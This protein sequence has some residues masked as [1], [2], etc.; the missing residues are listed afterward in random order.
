MSHRPA[1]SADLATIC[2]F[3]QSAEELFFLFPKATFPL[4]PEQLQRAMDQRADATV[5]ELRGQV[6][7]Y[8]NFYQ[9]AQGGRCAIGNVII[10]PA[11]RGQGVGRYLINR[12]V[13]LAISR[14]AA[15]EVTVACFNHNVSALLLYAGMGFEPYAIE[16]RVDHQGQRVA[17]IQLRRALPVG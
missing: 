1:T 4:T 2:G 14:Y 11:A 9:W 16:E 3:P 10:A 17:L 6:V 5:V 13:D 12:M 7:G 8:A 15:R